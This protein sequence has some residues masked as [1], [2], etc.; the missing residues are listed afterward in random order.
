MLSKVR[1]LL[2]D[3]ES[4]IVW[5]VDGVLALLEWGEYNHYDDD[6]ETWANNQK[7]GVFVYTDRFVIPKLQEFIKGKDP[8]RQFSISKAFTVHEDEDKKAYLNTNYEIPRENVFTVRSNEEKVDVLK[9]IKEKFFPDLDD[10]KFIMVED[11]VD[12]LTLIMEN[13]PFTT[14]HIST[15]LCM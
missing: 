11:S 12:I 5:D 15:F 13:T 9:R 8:A 2:N 3:P 7:E 14:V 4:V 1:E 10:H 6:D